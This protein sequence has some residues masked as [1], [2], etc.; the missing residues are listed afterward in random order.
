MKVI[1]IAIIITIISFVMVYN[2]IYSILEEIE[3]WNQKIID[4][5]KGK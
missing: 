3:Q 1:K 4:K 5:M 2:L